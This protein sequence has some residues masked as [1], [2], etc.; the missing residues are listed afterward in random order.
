M[1]PSALSQEFTLP[2]QELIRDR[3][4]SLSIGPCA[5]GKK[6]L[7]LSGL[8]FSRRIYIPVSAVRRVF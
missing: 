2:R 1:L 4:E 6:A 3:K 8:V 7:Y 5:I